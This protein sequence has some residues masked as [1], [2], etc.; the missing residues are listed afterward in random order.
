MSLAFTVGNPALR[1]TSSTTEPTAPSSKT[2]RASLDPKKMTKQELVDFVQGL[3]EKPVETT[4]IR[5]PKPA[6]NG[7]HPTMKPI[8]LFGRQINNSS[9]KGENVLD[10]FGGS[11]TT[12]IAC[13]QLGR[14]AYIM[15]LDP[16]Y[17]DV[18]IAR[19]EKFTGLTAIKG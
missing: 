6:R 14:K 8:K 5:E 19:W 3:L 15:E 4:V 17:C 2:Q 1:T 18:I 16:H 10:S 12:L 13:E 9:R 7:E 11:G